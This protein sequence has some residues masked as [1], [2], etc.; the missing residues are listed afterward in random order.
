[1]ALEKTDGYT[2]GTQFATEVMASL[3]RAGL[4]IA[5]PIALSFY[6]Y[7][8]SKSAATA[9]QPE[10]QAAGLEVEIEKSASGDG[11]WLCLCHHTFKPA[12]KTLASIGD[13]CLDLARKHRGQ[14]DGWETNPYANKETFAGLLQEMLKHLAPQRDE[15]PTQQPAR[16]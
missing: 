4:D 1:M 3:R 16:P 5:Q 13:L 9:C 14:F 7:L 12:P 10:L 6:L 8:P 2:S 15:T 11:E